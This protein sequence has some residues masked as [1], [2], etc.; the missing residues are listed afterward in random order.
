MIG[1]IS[2]GGYG[3]RL[4][5]LTLDKPREISRKKGITEDCYNINSLPKPL[6]PITNCPM[7]YSPLTKMKMLGV[8]KVFVT[9]HYQKEKFPYH[10][11]K[12]S[13]L[14]IILTSPRASSTDELLKFAKQ[15]IAK[16]YSGDFVYMNADIVSNI[17]PMPA[18]EAHKKQSPLVTIVSTPVTGNERRLSA[19][20]TAEKDIYEPVQEYQHKSTPKEAKANKRNASIY[21]FSQDFVAWV[22][23]HYLDLS[24]IELSDHIFPRLASSNNDL[25]FCYKTNV[26]WLDVGEIDYYLSAQKGSLHGE[27]EHPLHGKFYRKYQ[28]YYEGK[29]SVTG[30]TLIQEGCEIGNGTIIGPNTVIGKGW[31]IGNNCQFQGSVLWPNNIGEEY[32]NCFLIENNISLNNCAVG[33]GH[34]L[35]TNE[36]KVIVSNGEKTCELTWE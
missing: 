3:S 21:F 5:P 15:E 16:G 20:K 17:D 18:F 36:N 14:E 26:F 31:M 2:A 1:I 29:Y 24:G 4:F 23:E 7:I 6:A 32:N 22:Q 34:I 27:V 33:S 25:F 35:R 13:D 9:I 19:I 8:E 10:L 30:P 28:T 12:I 11:P